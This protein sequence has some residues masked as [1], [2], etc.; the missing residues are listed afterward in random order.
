MSTGTAYLKTPRLTFRW[1]TNEGSPTHLSLP[2]LISLASGALVSTFVALK[3]PLLV[4]SG[5]SGHGIIGKT[6]NPLKVPRMVESANGLHGIIG[7][8]V[9]GFELHRLVV[10]SEGSYNIT[11]TG[12][13]IAKPLEI[14]LTTGFAGHVGSGAIVVPRLTFSVYGWFNP[15]GTSAL[16]LPTLRLFSAGREILEVR[17]LKTPIRKGIAM[18]LVN[19]AVSEYTDYPFNSLVVFNGK[20]LGGKEDGIYDLDNGD[21][22]DGFP[23]NA[24]IETGTEDLFKKFMARLREIWIESRQD[25]Q[26]KLVIIGGEKETSPVAELPIVSYDQNMHEERVKGPRAL[27]ERYVAFRLENVNG[28]DVDIKKITAFKE[29][30]PRRR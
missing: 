3:L 22:D 2:S 21:D 6:S 12:L 13:V 4:T 17:P 14:V 24:Y 9:N 27:K 23:I 8:P 25:G 7:S 18:N 5:I 30:V 29:P 26:L 16:I 10:S 1:N 15:K 19:W 20:Q 28:S 11:G